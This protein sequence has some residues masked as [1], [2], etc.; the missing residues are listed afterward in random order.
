MTSCFLLLVDGLKFKLSEYLSIESSIT[1]YV[2]YDFHLLEAMGKGRGHK[3][4]THFLSF[5]MQFLV[6]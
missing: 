5:K 6:C 2:C 4:K 3:Q 1:D